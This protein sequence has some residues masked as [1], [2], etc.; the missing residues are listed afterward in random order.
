LWAISQNRTLAVGC[1]G[2][3]KLTSHQLGDINQRFGIFDI[4]PWAI[5]KEVE[6]I[7][8]TPMHVPSIIKNLG[9]AYD[10]KILLKDI[11]PEN[12][13]GSRLLD[14]GTSRTWPHPLWSEFEYISSR[15]TKS[16]VVR[17]WKFVDNHFEDSFTVP[18]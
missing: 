18:L 2:W 12:Y 3:T 10:A 16:A 15:E 4:S 14:L 13:K 9:I 5:I 17:N 7:D 11:R 6:N 1:H 8:S